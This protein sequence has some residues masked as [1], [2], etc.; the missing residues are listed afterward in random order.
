MGSF[1]F[2]KQDGIVFSRART[3]KD[4][5]K[6]KYYFIQKQPQTRFAFEKMISDYFRTGYK[7]IK[8][9]QRNFVL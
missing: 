1:R 4:N 6:E 3:K 2:Y 8:P 5:Q 7:V 9:L